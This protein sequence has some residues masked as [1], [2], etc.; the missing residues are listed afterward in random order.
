MNMASKT[1]EIE[2]DIFI[3]FCPVYAF[4]V[5]LLASVYCGAMNPIK[6]N[7]MGRI[8]KNTLSISWFQSFFLP[9]IYKFV[10]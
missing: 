7:E 4:Y 3:I 9:L 8:Y 5:L 10:F 1:K 6:N 2:Q